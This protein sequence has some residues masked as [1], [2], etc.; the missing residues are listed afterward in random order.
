M[1]S[2]PVLSG[3]YGVRRSFL[4]DS[5]FHSTKQYSTDIYSSSLGSKSIGCE[6]ASLQSYPP[7]LDPYFS[8]TIGDYRS[9]SITSAGSSLFSASSLPP[10]LPHFSVTLISPVTHR[11]IYCTRYGKTNDSVQKYNSSRKR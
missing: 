4:P 10:L 7:L 6:P 5:E 9:S 2:S 1:S 8:D 11:I 3:Y